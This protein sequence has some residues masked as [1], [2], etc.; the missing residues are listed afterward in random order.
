[1]CNYRSKYAPQQ[2]WGHELQQLCK[3]GVK[4]TNLACGGR[5]VKTFRKEGRWERL[6]GMAKEGDYVI[7]Q[8]GHNDSNFR[9]PKRYADVKKVFPELMTKCVEEA[10]AK[11]LHPILVSTTCW[12]AF[13]KNGKKGSSKTLQAYAD[14]AK[15]VAKATDVPYVDLYN[16]S[17]GKMQELGPEATKKNHMVA[18]GKDK[19][20]LTEDGAR[21][22][23]KWF[24]EAVQKDQLPLAK[25]FK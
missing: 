15:N 5:S 14:A 20:H 13:D 22:Y 1:M 21:A 6:L 8:F 10:K 25:M 9:R 24:V 16:F 18:V 4:V 11:K 7:I 2:G 23:A 3:P 17:I 19:L 12:W